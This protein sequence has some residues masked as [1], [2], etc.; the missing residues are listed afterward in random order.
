MSPQDLSQ[1]IV[2]FVLPDVPCL[3]TITVSKETSSPSPKEDEYMHS[4]CFFH[5]C[6]A[7]QTLT[8]ITCNPAAFQVRVVASSCVAPV[9][10][11]CAS[12][13][14]FFKLQFHMKYM[15]SMFLVFAVCFPNRPLCSILL[16]PPRPSP[17]PPWRSNYMML[18]SRTGA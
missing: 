5:I 9:R 1:P 7:M 10:P 11:H 6:T 8:S 17:T 13:T 14:S 18:Q 15:Q 4:S 3:P 12:L 2:I 16:T